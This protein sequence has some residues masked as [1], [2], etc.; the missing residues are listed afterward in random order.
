M[1]AAHGAAI[2]TLADAGVAEDGAEA[3]IESFATFEENAVAKARWFAGLLSDRVVIAEDSG[4][5]VDALF[6][7][8]GVRS[9]RWSED[10][11]W[12]VPSGAADDET[13]R[14]EAN[15]QRLLFELEAASRAGRST[16]SARYVCAA[17]CVWPEGVV[18]VRG[19]TAGTIERVRRGTGGFGYDPVFRSLELGATFAEVS[20][21]EKARVSHRGRAFDELIG[22][23]GSIER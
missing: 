4:L 7:A 23:L 9:K 8:P 19:E 1:F 18:V 14:D 22:R 2:E 13:A 15:T 17:A 5:E 3:L 16:R 6:G 10:D 21:E 20:R 11:G 12:W